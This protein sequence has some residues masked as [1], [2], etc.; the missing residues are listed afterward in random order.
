MR[1]AGVDVV[2]RYR[3]GGVFCTIAF[4]AGNAVEHGKL[5]PTSLRVR[6]SITC[7]TITCAQPRLLG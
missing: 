7:E 6:S 5:C 1:D 3:D 2:A 4:A